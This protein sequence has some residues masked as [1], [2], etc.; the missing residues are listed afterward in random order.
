MHYNLE[1]FE[2]FLSNVDL[3]KYRELY[4]P[5]KIV[6]MDLPKEIQALN[7]I[8]SLYWDENEVFNYLK[9]AAF[10]SSLK[11]KYVQSNFVNL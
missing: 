11:T 5:I 7:S 4:S 3:S 10:V 9:N 1:N 6:E 2:I 8:Y